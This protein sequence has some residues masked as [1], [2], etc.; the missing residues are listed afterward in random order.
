[1]P[2]Q[3]TVLHRVTPSREHSN[4][5]GRLNP[6][7]PGAAGEKGTQ[8]GAGTL[9]KVDVQGRVGEDEGDMLGTE[10]TAL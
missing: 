7:P 6:D 10:S 3:R 8:A 5:Q 4:H 2:S 9:W 1:M